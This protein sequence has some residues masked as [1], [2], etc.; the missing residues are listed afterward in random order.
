MTLTLVMLAGALAGAGA[1]LAAWML[2]QPSTSGPVALALLDARLARGRR[3]QSLTVDRRHAEESARMR[4]VG[5]RIG[6][7][8]ETQGYGLPRALEVDLGMVGQSRTPS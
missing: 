3:D 6:D 1:L 4:R 7:V 8:L 2:V 5:A